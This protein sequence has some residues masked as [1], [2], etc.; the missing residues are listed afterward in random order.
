MINTF[1]NCKDTVYKSFVVHS[2]PVLKGFIADR[3]TECGAP[4]TVSF[5]DTTADA[6][7]W[8]WNWNCTYNCP[9]ADATIPNPVQSFTYANMQFV[10]LEVTNA[11]GCTTSVLQGV[12]LTKPQINIDMAQSSTGWRYGCT[13]MNITFKARQA[14]LIA[15][16]KW[17]FSDDNSTS[18]EAVP[19]HV[20]NASGIFQVTLNYVLKNGCTGTCTY[21][22]IRT[23]TK[24]KFDFVSLSG[25]DICGNT[26]VRFSANSQ[27]N[28]DWYWF[29]GDGDFKYFVNG[30]NGYVEHKYENE[31]TYTVTV[32]SQI[33]GCYD[34]LTKTDYIKINLPITKIKSY[35][36][37][38]DGPR[39]DVV[40]TDGSKG[41]ESW[42]WDFGDGTF[43]AY[44]TPPAEI[45]HT[46]QK[47]GDYKT[48]LT[49]TNGVC[50]VKDSVITH[51]YLK[52]NPVLSAPQ[53]TSCSDKWFEISI[54]N[55]EN[56]TQ[57]YYNWQQYTTLHFE[58]GDGRDAALW[59][60]S[61][62]GYDPGPN[63]KF[64]LLDFERGP[65]QLRV[66][67]HSDHYFCDDTTNFIPVNIKGPVAGFKWQPSYCSG[68]SV[69]F[70]D[71]SKTTGGVPIVSY[72]WTFGDGT[73][74]TY[75]TSDPVVHTYPYAYSYDINYRVVDA[76][77]CA[78]EKNIYYLRVGGV[79]AAFTA[80]ATTVS[81]NTEVV[82]SNSSFDNYTNSTSFQWIFGDG[83]SST[84]RDAKHTYTQPGTYMVLLLATNST[85]GCTDTARQVIVVKY[86]NSAFSIDA[87]YLN[88]SSCPP[89]LVRF[90]NKS[91]N[92]SRVSWEFGD[93]IRSENVSNPSHLYTRSG[94]YFVT[95]H[96]YSDNGTE[97]NTTDSVFIRPIATPALVSDQLIAC[98]SGTIHFQ[99]PGSRFAA[100]SWDF[101]DGNVKQSTDSFAIYNYQRAGS[102]S[103]TLLVID[104]GG[105]VSA[106]KMNEN[107]I[108]DS[109][110]IDIG[111]VSS[112]CNR[113]QI[114]FQ[115][116]VN[117]VAESQ[118]KQLLY[119]WDFGTGNVGD[120]ANIKAASFLYQSP[121]TYTVRFAVTSPSG[122]YRQTSKQVV[123]DE[124]IKGI[125][126]GPSDLC[127][128]GTADFSAS[129][130]SGNPG[131]NW[132][133]G[134]GGTSTLQTP[135]TQVF[136]QAGTY[137]II[138]AIRNGTCIDTS[139][140][141]LDVHPLP[142]INMQHRVVLC[143]GSS[144]QLAASGG[145]AYQWQPSTGLSDPTISSP[146]A[147]PSNTTTYTL[148]AQS[149]LGC[150]A[151]DTV[152]VTVAPLMN[153]Q[154]S[155]N[156]T[157][158][159]GSRVQLIAGGAAS[160][161]W[162]GNTVG[163]SNT[164]IANPFAAP[165]STTIYAVKG[166]DSYNC[167]TDTARVTVT[168]APLPTVNAGS[169]VLVSGGTPHTL[170][171]VYSND[172]TV[173]NWSPATNLS[174]SNCPSP[175]LTPLSDISYIIT[176]KNADGCS[177]SDTIK[178]ATE[179]GESHVYIPNAFTPNGDSKNNSFRIKGGG[180]KMVKH[181]AI[182]SRWGEVVFQK[183]NFML[184]DVSATWDGNYRGVPVPQG[185][186]VYI[187]SFECV[188]GEVF[189]RKGT[190]TVIL[191]SFYSFTFV[192]AIKSNKKWN[193]P[194]WRCPGLDSSIVEHQLFT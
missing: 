158:C 145:S 13:G 15:S 63:M 189:T 45:K 46:Y 73:K 117:S 88:N 100:Y 17:I 156:E 155:G 37:T 177:A 79:K 14:D 118:G 78:D 71:T 105:C 20:F 143:Y 121:G 39:G 12:D 160:Y 104:T 91:A 185:T 2:S 62:T 65:N 182:Y 3:S 184:D 176:V 192:I 128:G 181:I 162:I 120:T 23:R 157:I 53:V 50:T 44:T 127:A 179:C 60:I 4:A 101:G 109:L 153:L 141:Q 49:T 180:V 9:T 115:P 166:T 122:C 134:Q 165:R 77:G 34:T 86:I 38:C 95:L 70:T 152:R 75:S 42:R 194:L 54:D 159:T 36:N 69:T 175:V 154:L 191:E 18:T 108:I 132:N 41:A 94:T 28:Q 126:T 97:Y 114:Q 40:F 83:G 107:I 123:V 25:T 66:I 161:Q 138:L 30:T 133:F 84:G 92:A 81:P 43:L 129:A 24:P 148:T 110:Q 131:W 173:W 172:V 82:F 90:T 168:V 116:V 87:G 19:N 98:T 111:T 16:Y 7:K 174:C 139:Y 99:S 102:Y 57:A 68:N 64:G 27:E 167:F 59:G 31:G 72:N 187:A 52:Q 21:D 178:I 171:P 22:D 164:S 56:N 29:F 190:V 74:S 5:R 6:V 112:G 96:S 33:Q 150:R 1:G 137:Q 55:I 26:P 186:Y 8:K 146:L 76:D 48:V 125:I 61:H 169:D 170:Q 32:I 183:D 136:Q 51:V 85:Y 149:A 142:T 193:S 144:I 124:K 93:G 35:K 67:M 80:S 130:S 151:T 103:P 119:S 10:R 140:H 58:Y 163:L 47:T 147:T 188:S 106:V 11:D 135:P 89:V 113:V